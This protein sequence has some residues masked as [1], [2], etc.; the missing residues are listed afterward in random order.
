MSVSTRL[1]VEAGRKRGIDIQILSA[2]K[3]TYIVNI[4]GKEHVWKATSFGNTAS[5][6]RIC[7]D[8][9][10]THALLSKWGYRIPESRVFSPK[11]YEEAIEWATKTQSI[12]MKP[13]AG[14]HGFG[15]T[16][17]PEGREEVEDAWN[18]VIEASVAPFRVQVEEFVPGEDYRFLVVGGR[19]VYVIHR[20]PATI[21]GDG[22]QTIE[23]LIRRENTRPA[24][25]KSAYTS[26]YSPIDI[27]ASLRQNLKKYG[28]TLETILPKGKKA[29]LRRVCNAG[30]G[31]TERDVTSEIAET[32]KA[33]SV[34]LTKKLDMDILAIDVRAQ[35]I[36]K[37]TTFQQMHILE[38]NST[39]GTT[40]GMADW[41]SDAVWDGLL[42]KYS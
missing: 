42:E 1:L 32:L 40:L 24:R 38:L 22:I 27:D 4:G 29:V 7:S 21:F 30:K 18:R 5:V 41:V 19:C 23:N 25:G 12:V 8:K 17:L 39:P 33:E 13:L 15:I 9:A 35:D 26:F 11:R 2:S 3:N 37:L 6:A 10:L 34:E 36:E 31:G 28:Y 16:V 14:A 20:I